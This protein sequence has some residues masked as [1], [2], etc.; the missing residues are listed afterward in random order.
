M[1]TT[2]TCMIL[3]KPSSDHSILCSKSLSHFLSD[4]IF[5]CPRLPYPQSTC[6]SYICLPVFLWKPQHALSLGPRHLLFPLPGMLFPCVS[7]KLA[8]SSLWGHGSNVFWRRPSLITLFNIVTHSS[9]PRNPN[10]CFSPALTAIWH[11]LPV[12]SLPV[13]P[14]G[15]LSVFFTDLSTFPWV[16]PDPE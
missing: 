9:N 3:L 12:H 8:I 1:F 15:L 13:P 10:F 4:L 6:S 16:G 5:Y 14:T 11:I 2:A 7:V